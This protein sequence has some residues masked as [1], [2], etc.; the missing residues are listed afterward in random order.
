VAALTVAP[1]GGRRVVAVEPLTREAFRAYGDVVDRDFD[2]RF[3]HAINEGTAWRRHDLARIDAAAGGHV[4]ISIVRAEP[5]PLPF[6]LQCLER[7]V[8]GN[9]AF[10]PLDGARWLVVVAT[11]NDEPDLATLRAFVA[12]ARQG[13][14]YARG[15]WH[16]PLLAIERAADFVVVDR[17]SD[18]GSDDCE[19]RDLGA[20]DLWIVA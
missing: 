9:Q 10:V 2:D 11:R 12:S 17:V 20:L 6:R 18:E 16:H 1:A 8:L 3:G 4:A 7:H 19:V 14:S 13:V 5:R 15:T